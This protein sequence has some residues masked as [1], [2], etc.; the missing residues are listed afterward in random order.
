[1]TITDHDYD[2]YITTL[3][4][5]KSTAE[6]FAARLAQSNV[7]NKSDIANFVKETKNRFL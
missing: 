2:K 3:E 5:D 1:M 6:N 7:A 4:F